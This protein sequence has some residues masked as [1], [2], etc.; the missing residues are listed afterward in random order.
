MHVA[1]L[2]F[3]IWHEL[4]QIFYS[5]MVRVRQQS[6]RCDLQF[7]EYLKGAVSSIGI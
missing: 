7:M 1:I 4:S 6:S 2:H 3:V 5:L